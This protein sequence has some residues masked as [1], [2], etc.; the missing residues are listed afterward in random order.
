MG[1]N[2]LAKRCVDIVP[3]FRAERER[4]AKRIM[5]Y[6]NAAGERLSHIC[7]AGKNVIDKDCFREDVTRDKHD[8]QE[9]PR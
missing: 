5:V 2:L 3:A 1:V 7:H 8:A 6:A 4:T 9:N